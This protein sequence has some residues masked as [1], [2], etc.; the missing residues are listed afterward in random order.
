MQPDLVFVIASRRD[1]VK[2]HGIVGPADLVVEIF[3]PGTEEGDRNYNLTM[4]ARHSVSEYWI[5]APDAYTIDIYGAGP[6]EYLAPIRH[7]ESA[8]ATAH[9][10]DL[11][12]Q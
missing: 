9:T 8:I 1:L 11:L 2:L 10:V 6:A 4:Y 7:S 5:V 3:S 12:L